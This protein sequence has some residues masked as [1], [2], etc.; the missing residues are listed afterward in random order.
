VTGSPKAPRRLRHGRV[1]RAQGFD[2]RSLRAELPLRG[3]GV[4]EHRPPAEGHLGSSRTV[5]SETAAPNVLV[6]LV[7]SGCAVVQSADVAEPEGH[8]PA[9]LSVFR[10]VRA[11]RALAI[12][13]K[14][15]IT[16]PVYFI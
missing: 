12:G 7:W 15:I 2:G 5:V 1:L 16:H 3:A 9:P 6:N 8:P 14:A 10:A 13:R 11:Q 4:V